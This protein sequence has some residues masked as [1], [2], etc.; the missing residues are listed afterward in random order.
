MKERAVGEVYNLYANT[1]TNVPAIYVVRASQ[2][3]ATPDARGTT[4]LPVNNWS[5]VAATYNGS[6]LR[7]YVNGQQ[8]G[9]RSISGSLLTS[10]GALKVGGN[11]IW[12]EYFEGRIDEIRIYNRGLS[13]SE[14]LADMSV[15]IQ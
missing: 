8:V 5:H 15:P 12:G 3:N 9:S 10:T 11:S 6:T 14:I 7:L 1:D 13:Q 4:Q 2:P